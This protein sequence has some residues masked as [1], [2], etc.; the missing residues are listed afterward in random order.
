MYNFW[1]KVSPPVLT[2]KFRKICVLLKNVKKLE[3]FTL[4]L[5]NFWNFTLSFTMA[6]RTHQQIELREK[7]CCKIWFKLLEKLKKLSCQLKALS[8]LRRGVN[9]QLVPKRFSRY[10]PHKLTLT[11]GVSLPYFRGPVGISGIC[12]FFQFCPRWVFKNAHI[13]GG[14]TTVFLKP[15]IRQKKLTLAPESPIL[16]KVR[17]WCQNGSKPNI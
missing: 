5:K 9:R 10:L 12:F 13:F 8:L 1:P 3:N 14:F 15:K 17:K 11:Q 2:S 16:L 6:K 4:S 7:K